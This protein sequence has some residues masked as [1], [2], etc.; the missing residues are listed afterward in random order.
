[1]HRDVSE[2]LRRSF[3]ARA[4]ASFVIAVAVGFG[5]A[6]LLGE[7][8]GSALTSSVGVGIGVVIAVLFVGTATDAGDVE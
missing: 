6:R 8:T 4:A 3:G 7:P 1:M 2:T 5:V